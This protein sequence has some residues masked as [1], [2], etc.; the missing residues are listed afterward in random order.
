VWGCSCCLILEVSKDFAIWPIFGGAIT[1]TFHW[2]L[3]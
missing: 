1:T 2:W 3:W